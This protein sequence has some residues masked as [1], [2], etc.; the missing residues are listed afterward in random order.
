M[1]G[2]SWSWQCDFERTFDPS[3]SLSEIDTR[4]SDLG[5]PSDDYIIIW[6]YNAP[7]AGETYIRTYQLKTVTGTLIASIPI[8]IDIRPKACLESEM[9][10]PSLASQDTLE[11]YVF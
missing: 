4:I 9:V 2:T 1:S 7:P 3:G 5:D 8:T 6:P 10:L 11:T